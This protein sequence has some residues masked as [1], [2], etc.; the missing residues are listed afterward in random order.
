MTENKT[1]ENGADVDAYLAS[2]AGAGRAAD[3]FTLKA[4][5]ERAT[6]EPARMWGSSIVGF[7]RY[8]Y[9]YASGREGDFMLTG[10]AP[11]KAQLTIYIMPGFEPYREELARLGKH[12]TAK[13]CLYIKRLSDVDAGILEGI[14]AD[15]VI[16][17]RAA[18]PDSSRGSQGAP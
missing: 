18:Y 10:F 7:G 3:C 9:R 16:R 4:M 11:R 14:I 17:M 1:R 12:K 8:H 2:I 15:S 5:M 6:G 13:S